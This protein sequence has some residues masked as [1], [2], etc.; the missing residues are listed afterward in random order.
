MWAEHSA[1]SAAPK[2]RHP[3]GGALGYRSV[4]LTI[5]LTRHGLTDKSIPEHYLGQRITAELTESGR[6][7]AE[8][9]GARLEGIPFRRV[10][11]S[12]LARARDTAVIVARGRPVETD[13]RLAEMDYGEWEGLTIEEIEQRYS[14]LRRRW[15]DDPATVRCPGGENGSEVER[16]VRGL[17]GELIDPPA[18]APGS[19]SPTDVPADAAGLPVLLVGHSS[20]NRILLTSMLGVPLRDYRRRFVQD[21]A[22]LTVLR[23]KGSLDDG[24]QLVLANDRAHLVGVSGATWD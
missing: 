6:T 13:A 14:D 21:W 10:I 7:A 15:E 16:R 24:A 20:V 3:D 17:L 19:E 8:A 5:V 12:P 18:T 11:S 1:R 9:L 2:P 22:S 23:F 4:V